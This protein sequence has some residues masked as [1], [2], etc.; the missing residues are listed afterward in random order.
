MKKTSLASTVPIFYE[1]CWV[2]KITH[3]FINQ[4]ISHSEEEM[5]YFLGYGKS[6][7]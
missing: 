5:N 4:K 7:S 6:L 3:H 2:H 1:L